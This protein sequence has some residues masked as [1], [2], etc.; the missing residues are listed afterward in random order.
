MGGLTK[1]QLHE[2]ARKIIAGHKAGCKATVVKV[3][4]I[5]DGQPTGFEF[6][7]RGETVAAIEVKDDGQ[8]LYGGWTVDELEH[9]SLTSE[10]LQREIQ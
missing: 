9:L 6:D 1:D 2:L 4:V 7:G 10:L 3:G 5:I 8:I